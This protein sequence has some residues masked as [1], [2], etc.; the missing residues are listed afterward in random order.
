MHWNE[1][2]LPGRHL[3]GEGAFCGPKIESQLLLDC[4]GR[5]PGVVPCSTT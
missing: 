1:A 3:P 4:L 2:G 5:V